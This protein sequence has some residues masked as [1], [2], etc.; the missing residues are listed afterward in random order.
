MAIGQAV[1]VAVF[2]AQEGLGDFFEGHEVG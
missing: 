2:C 1:D